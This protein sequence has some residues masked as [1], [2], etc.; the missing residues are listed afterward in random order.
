MVQLIRR[1]IHKR[2]VYVLCANPGHEN[3]QRQKIVKILVE[4]VKLLTT[5]MCDGF[6]K[7]YDELK[8]TKQNKTKQKNH[9]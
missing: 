6:R 5:R 8:Q 9:P 7:T 2:C 1:K 4:V 3:V